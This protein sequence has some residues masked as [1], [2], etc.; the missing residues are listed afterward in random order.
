MEEDVEEA[1]NQYFRAD[2]AYST[3]GDFNDDVGD[4]MHFGTY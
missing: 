3:G 2:P 4:D 1:S